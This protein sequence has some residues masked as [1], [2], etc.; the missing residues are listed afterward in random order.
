MSSQ[1][2]YDKHYTEYYPNSFIN[3]T[4]KHHGM[5]KNKNQIRS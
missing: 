3:K 1:E 4:E 2:W 5:W